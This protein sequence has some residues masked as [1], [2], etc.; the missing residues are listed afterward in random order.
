MILQ[1]ASWRFWEKWNPYGSI[2]EV[3]DNRGLSYY[4]RT[5]AG[6]GTAEG[7]P[8]FYYNPAQDSYTSATVEIRFDNMPSPEDLRW[9]ELTIGALIDAYETLPKGAYS[10]ITDNVIRMGLYEQAD[11]IY[12]QMQEVRE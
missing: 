11:R 7:I 2:L 4:N 1:G 9:L 5:R 6:G 3:R 8:Q 12:S 10:E